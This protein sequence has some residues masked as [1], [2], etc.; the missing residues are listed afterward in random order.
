MIHTV[1]IDNIIS[2]NIF[3]YIKAHCI[4]GKHK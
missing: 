3:S 1:Q 4:N 2:Y